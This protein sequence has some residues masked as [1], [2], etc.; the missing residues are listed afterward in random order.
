MPQQQ[1]ASTPFERGSPWQPS[2]SLRARSPP[3][4]TPQGA[5]LTSLALDGAEYLWQGDPRWWNRQAPVLFPIVGSIRDNKATSAQGPI[6]LG[7]HGLARNY[8]YRVTEQ[9]A[10]SVTLEL[11]DAPE[12]R[13]VFPYAFR[14]SMTYALT[15]PATLKQT[16]R[17]E[18]TG[19]VVLPFSVGGHPAVQRPRARHRGRDVGGLRA[20]VRR[21]VDL[22][23]AGRHR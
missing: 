1:S 21:A 18:N 14:L 9:T 2:P 15:G 20:G 11:T 7:R 12:T 23:V 19:D 16:F 5:Q 6:S 4:S 3:P 13:E 10:D 22:R 8:A 17:V